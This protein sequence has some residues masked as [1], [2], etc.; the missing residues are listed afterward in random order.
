MKRLAS[1]LL[2]PIAAAGADFSSFPGKH[3]C[4]AL[5]NSQECARSLESALNVP[6]I[7]RTSEAEAQVTL[8][9]G[10]VFP[11]KDEKVEEGG[12]SYS[13][14]EVVLRGRFAIVHRQFWEGSAYSLLDRS[15]GKVI[16]LSGYPV[17]SSDARWLAVA[18]ADLDAGYSPNTLQIYRYSDG[19]LSLS[20]DA[21][22]DMWGPERVIWKSPT[23]LSYTHAT[24]ECHF[25]GKASCKAV[26]LK[27]Q[28]DRWR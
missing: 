18:S 14:V 22:P 25:E 4:P 26:V 23:E 16:D 28:G 7:K 21:K 1:I 15:S 6:Y 5:T 13:V 17:F 20:F 27:L 11:L 12:I 10:R 9:D 8:L 19:L 2:F 3:S 24:F